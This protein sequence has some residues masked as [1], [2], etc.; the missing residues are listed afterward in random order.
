MRSVVRILRTRQLLVPIGRG[1]VRD[2]AKL[3]EIDAGRR[4]KAVMRPSHCQL[5][6]VGMSRQVQWR[7][8]SPDPAGYELGEVLGRGRRK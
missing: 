2:V 4:H 8:C 6:A 3:A 1:Q 7:A 5:A